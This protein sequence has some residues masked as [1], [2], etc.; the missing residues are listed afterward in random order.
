VLTGFN[1]DIEHAGTVYHVQ[2]EDKGHANPFVESLVY[3]SGEILYSRRTPY[4]DL[5][6]QE[7][8]PKTV[9]TIMERQHRTIVDAIG[10]GKLEQLMGKDEE[11]AEEDDTTVSHAEPIAAHGSAEPSLDQVIL[12]YLEAQRVQAHLILRAT[13]DHDFTYGQTAEVGIVAVDSLSNEPQEDVHVTVLFKS[14]ADPR[15]LVLAEGTTDDDGSFRAPADLP[16]Y[17]GGTS[18]VVIVAASEL[19]QSEIK[20][21]VHR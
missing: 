18:A 17:N 20:H 4:H 14:T 15:R 11:A 3:A 2:T 9:A 10:S 6:E 5:L 21:L 16:A 8:D 12:E 19:G 13:A 7:I 1:T